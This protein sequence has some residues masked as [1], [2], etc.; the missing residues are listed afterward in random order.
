MLVYKHTIEDYL[1]HLGWT[2]TDE[3]LGKRFWGWAL[4]DGRINIHCALSVNDYDAGDIRLSIYSPGDGEY[5]WWPM[6]WGDGWHPF[7]HYPPSGQ[8][9]TFFETFDAWETALK[10]W[11]RD[12]TKR[13]SEQ[14]R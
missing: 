3:R 6:N 10:Q 11:I 1:H 13:N 2:R 12:T 4:D 9:I 7:Y 5:S 8:L 14:P